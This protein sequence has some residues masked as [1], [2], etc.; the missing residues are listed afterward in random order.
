MRKLVVPALLIFALVLSG[1]S[2]SAAEAALKVGDEAI[3][4]IK[5]EAE[6][7]VPEELAKLTEAAAN[8]KAK[9]DEGKYGE[10]LTRAQ[11]LP[12]KANAVAVAAKMKKDELTRKW[13]AAQGSVPAVV[14]E[15]TDR[16]GTLTAMKKLPKGIDKAKVDSAK[17]SLADVTAGWTAATEA[18]TGGDINGALAKADAAK[19]RAEELKKALEAAP[20]AKK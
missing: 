18:F 19:T 2:K 6:K 4:K 8:A 16:I 9:L 20:P 15:V 17:A 1:C 3:A 7:Y 14:K 5:P 11:E 13:D 10:A 12:A